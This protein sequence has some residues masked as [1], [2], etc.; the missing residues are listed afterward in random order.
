MNDPAA[1]LVKTEFSMLR[2]RNRMGCSKLIYLSLHLRL[3]RHE[4]SSRIPHGHGL[5]HASERIYC[6]PLYT[7]FSTT[8]PLS[9]L[10]SARNANTET[11][12][13]RND[14][15]LSQRRSPKQQSSCWANIDELFSTVTIF[16]FFFLCCYN[17]LARYIFSSILT[18]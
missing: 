17:I 14:G 9:L 18:D 10:H 8:L 16:F 4:E 12:N 5:L 13:I 7:T 1:Q 6:S 3:Q 15:Q 11:D 2:T